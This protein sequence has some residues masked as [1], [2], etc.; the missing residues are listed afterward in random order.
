MAASGSADLQDCDEK[1]F[2]PGERRALPPFSGKLK[3]DEGLK[4]SC[5]NFTQSIGD[6][7][8]DKN[9]T[10]LT[11]LT[12]TPPFPT[13]YVLA[14]FA[15]KAYTDYESKETDEQYETRL[16][17]LEGWKLLTTAS[18]ITKTNGYFGAAYWHPE[19]QEVVIA[20]RGTKFTNL[21]ALWTDL[22]G[23]LRNKY[24][25]QM[26]SASTFAH[27][28]VEV[29]QEVA[30][31][32]RVSFQLFFTGHSL[33]GWL[34]QITTFTTEYLKR[35]GKFFL[36]IMDDN[37]CYHP[38]TVVFDSPGCKDMLLL[39]TDKLDVRLDGRSIDIEHLDITS[40]L[41]APNRIN[42]CRTHLG[43]VYRIFPDFSDM[44]WL[45]RHTAW[46]TLETHSMQKIVEFF[47]TK[48]VQIDK[49]EQDKLQI[50]V[51][52]DWPISAGFRQ[53][54]DYERFFKKAKHLNDYHLE[55][56]DVT[57]QNES[58][59]PLR[60]Q[61]KPYDE[62]GRRLNELCQ[63][64]RQFLESYRWLLQLPEFFNPKELFAVMEDRKVQEKAEKL[65]QSFEI[66][67]DTIRCTDASALQALIPYVKRLLQLFPQ[68]K[69][70]TKRALLS[71]E[72][73]NRVYQFETRRYVEWI[74]Q[75]P[76]EFKSDASSLREFLEN[77]EQ[78]VLNLQMVNG[79]EWTGVI[80]VYQVLQKTACLSAGQ[81]TVLKLERLL[82]LNQ[83]MD[84]SKLMQSTVTPHLLLIACEDNQQWDEE[85]KNVIGTLFDT[86][87]RKPNIKI[88]FFT[89]LEGRTV[90]FLH[91]VG[92][93]IFWKRFVRRVQ[94]LA[95]SDLTTSS[96]E[97]LLEKSV[98]FQAARIS[99][100]EILFAQSTAATFLPIGALLEE[101]ELKIADPVPISNDYNES[102]YIGRTLRCQ[103][104]IKQAIYSDKH[105]KEKHGFLASTEQE[106]RQLC[107]QYPNSNVHR[108]EKDKSGKLVW[109]QSQGS[110]ETLRRY[111]DTE[112]SRAYTPD[113]LDKLLELARHQKVMLISDTAGMGK[114][115]LLTHL[116]KEI[117]QKFPAKWLVRMDLNDHTE[118]LKALKR[119]Q[120]DKEKA[121]EFV[122]EKVLKLETGLQ[123]ELF[124]QGCG[125]NEKVRI[126]I[127]LDGFD[128]ISP[129][130]KE[131]VLNLLRA[132]RQTAVEQLW[133]TTRPHLRQELEDTLQQLSYTLEPFSEENQVVFLTKF[134]SLK[135]WFTEMD[136]K[137]IES[138]KKK[139]QIYA[140]KLIQKLSRSISDKGREF[141]GIPLQTRMLAEAFDKE[142]RT[143]CQS[144]ES[145]PELEVNLELFGLYGRFIE[146]KYE[147]YLEEKLQLRASNVAAKGLREHIL[148]SM[149]VG[150]QLLAL[151]VFF[152]E[153]IVA[154][155]QNKTECSFSNE[156]MTRFGIV[157]VSNDGKLQFIH[158]TFA[159][160]FVADC[161]VKRLTDG[162]NISE[163]V[164][165][166]ILEKIFVQEQYQVI[167]VFIDCLLLISSPSDEVLKQCGNRINKFG[168]YAGIILETAARQV[169]AKIL[170]FLL[171]SAQAAGH[172][173]GLH[174]MLLGHDKN[175]ETFW[176]LAAGRGNIE[177][178]KKI[179]EWVQE[180]LTTE[181]KKNKLLLRTDGEGRTVWHFA[182]S[183]S[184]LD[185]MQKIRE[186]AE[187][188]LTTEEI[189]NGIL[190]RTD[191][192]G[193]TAWH[194]AANTGKIDVMQKIW[195]WA[196][197]ILT[198]EEIKNEILLRTGRGGKTVWHL[199]SFHS[200]LDIIQKIW[201]W[202]TEKLTTEEIKNE[203]VLRT[204]SEGRTAWHIAVSQ[205][206]LDIMQKI[207]EWATEKLTTEEIKNEMVLRTDS[208]GRTAWHIVVSPGKLDIMQKIWEWATE[209]LTTEDM[210]NEMLLRTDRG[211]RTVWHLAVYHRILDMQKLWEWAK[212]KLSRE[213]I[214]NEML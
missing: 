149:R 106:F 19:H 174:E 54:E 98:K 120:I 119:E 179:W 95:W 22:N 40:Y 196:E 104:D 160:Y 74:S 127:M 113:D 88:I 86:I 38:H 159:E 11:Q 111:I 131:T 50:L 67:E 175:R 123:L 136:N 146:R 133:I 48:E 129:D 147:I 28:V 168:D 44:S 132:L 93:R 166:L 188:K 17:L 43:T 4:F 96:Q 130:Y 181:E 6:F 164:L 182:A 105:V 191:L 167:R 144:S 83:M 60:Y 73:R 102:Y 137:E 169:N 192:V 121:I 142:I 91:H 69:E 68:I 157:Q 84:L 124:K 9:L 209:K 154:L 139:L 212:E 205:G 201:E 29:L 65:L 20:H 213:E 75:S 15:S 134:W 203:M 112:N 64:E 148:K 16:A 5:E 76:L 53:G 150:H 197:E 110:L 171:D 12:A 31:T 51:V 56:T 210:K 18:N 7:Y 23:V 58:Y 100:N 207:W 13:P 162:R 206:E 153:Q 183:Q 172:T 52:I 173:E 1:N 109:Q 42:T 155:F 10:P 107:R 71:D 2:Q 45:G 78:K 184:K 161:M 99:L 34:A 70:N 66:E 63:Q 176:E 141:T 140:K 36:R 200:K 177:V 145:M 25:R 158:R 214:K 208:K 180:T 126:V 138:S 85:T 211:R 170:G 62:R 189:K 82:T 14:Q 57:S 87:K 32:K 79:D 24:V 195:E 21:G 72:V 37:D 35:E 117:K 187:E 77:E 39:M 55:F 116:C 47:Q 194:I 30:Q 193:W 115:T 128:E 26:E 103:I 27:K 152:T 198:T 190:L 80:K 199:A 49:D 163:Q 94:E 122:S 61:T 118:G 114:S 178:I 81:Y 151:K 156:D 125:Q 204:D 33:G 202:A 8:K 89:R 3:V 41:S 143:I 97:K 90:D 186:Y 108:L 165:D 135:D 101:K 46:Y 92:R 59:H 185:V